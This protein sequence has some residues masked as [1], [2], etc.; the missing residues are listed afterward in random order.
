MLSADLHGRQPVSSHFGAA[1]KCTALC[2]CGGRHYIM[3][4]LKLITQGDTARCVI[5]TKHYF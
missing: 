2:Q 4:K 1:L 3:Q 5:V